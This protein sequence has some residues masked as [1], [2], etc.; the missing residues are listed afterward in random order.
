MSEDNGTTVRVSRPDGL[1]IG[2]LRL[3]PIFLVIGLALLVWNGH[4]VL[5]AATAK[6]LGSK[7]ISCGGNPA[8]SVSSR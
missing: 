2:L 1:A 5:G 8:C 6:I 7:I 4:F 3:S